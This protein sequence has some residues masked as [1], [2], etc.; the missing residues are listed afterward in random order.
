MAGFHIRIAIKRDDEIDEKHSKTY[1][2]ILRKSITNNHH[3]FRSVIRES[4][5]ARGSKLL[6]DFLSINHFFDVLIL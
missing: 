6:R 5:F 3:T 2:V 1:R 4:L